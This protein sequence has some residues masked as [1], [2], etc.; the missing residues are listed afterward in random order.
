MCFSPQADLVGGVVIGA[1]G[2]DVLR[3]VE[4][5]RRYLPLAALPLVF[6]AHQLDEAVVWWSLQGHVGPTI[7]SVATWIYLLIAFV[8]LPV[9]VPVAILLIEPPGPR[10]RMI[11]VFVA[12]GAVVSGLLF[13][14]MVT[15]PVTATLADWHVSY[16]TGIPAAFWVVTAYVAATCGA[17]LFSGNRHLAVFGMVNLVAA[18]A[19]AV[20][21]GEGLASL[22][23]AWAA[24][25]SAAFAVHLRLEPS[26]R[27]VALPGVGS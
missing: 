17:L 16:G 23:C 4:G 1:I 6:A 10:R 13:A 12:L 7:G 26:N 2:I 20:I 3:H 14:A 22:W 9:Y 19:I 18:A 5:R 11:G 15:G 25:A 8:V 21:A 27:D 24:V